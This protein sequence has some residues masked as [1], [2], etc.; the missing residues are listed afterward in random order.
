[1]ASRGRPI[2]IDGPIHDLRSFR[3]DMELYRDCQVAC[4]HLRK[5]FTDVME[6][7]LC[8]WLK[9]ERTKWLR[10]HGSAWEE[11]PNDKKVKAIEDRIEEIRQRR[12]EAYDEQ[13]YGEQ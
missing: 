6:T 13:G 9:A 5:P 12:Q 8:E 7:L 3:I 11:R 10:T 2:E 4:Y 1:M